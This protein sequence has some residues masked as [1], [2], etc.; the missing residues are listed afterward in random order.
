LRLALKNYAN[1]IG[2]TFQITD[3]LL[4]IEGEKEI[5]G[6]NVSKDASLGKATYITCLG[7]EEAKEKAR[8]LTAEAINYLAP[9]DE[10]AD[11]LRRLAEYILLRK[12]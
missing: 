7:I 10:A 1:N 11:P 3:D 8:N 5:V 9:F 4:D 2:L 12:K 6:K